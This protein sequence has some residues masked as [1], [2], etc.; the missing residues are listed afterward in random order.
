MATDYELW[1]TQHG[2]ADVQG[3]QVI[4][5]AHYKFGSFYVSDYGAKFGALTESA[6]PFDAEP[7]AFELDLP[8]Q[9]NSTQSEMTIRMDAL[10]GF[11]MS[12]IRAMTDDERKIPIAV[13]LRFYLDNERDAPTLDPLAFVVINVNAT[14][15]AVELSCAATILPNIAAGTRYTMENFPSLSFL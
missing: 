15:V 7:V 4:E 3:V 12:Q 6:V 1:A 5:F 10:S 9:Q 8:K 14:R 11:I 2:L 13:I